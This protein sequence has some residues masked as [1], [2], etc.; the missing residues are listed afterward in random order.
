MRGCL[1][2]KVMLTDKLSILVDITVSC[3]KYKKVLK[4]TFKKKVIF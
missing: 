1:R 3:K 4:V 2:S